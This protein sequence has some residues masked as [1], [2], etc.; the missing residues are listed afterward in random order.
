M[1]KDTARSVWARL[2]GLR[3]SFVTRCERFASLTIPKVLLPEG[4]DKMGNSQTHDYQSMG[5]QCVNHTTNKMMLAMFAP[6]RPFFRMQAGVKTQTKAAEAGVTAE[7]VATIT[8]DAERKAVRKLDE[9]AQ[10][11]KLYALLRHLIV[12]GNALLIRE[13]TSLRVMGLRYFCVK[14]TVTGKVHTLIIKEAV[15]FDELEQAIQ[16]VLPARLKRNP[17]SKIDFFKWIKLEDDGSYTMTQWVDDIDLGT[18]AEKYN[19]VWA[20]EESCPYTVHTWDLADEADYGTGLVEEYEGDFEALS[21]LSEAVVDGAIL[22]TEFRWMCA[23]TGM[24]QVADVQNSKNGDVLAGSIADLAPTQGG[25]PQALQQA[26]AVLTRWEQRIGRG[27][28]MQSAV[29]RDAERVTA[30]EVRMAAFE[31]ETAFGGVYSALAP[32]IQKPLAKWLLALAGVSLD[33]T[34]FTLTIVTGLEAL[35]RNGD[36]DNLRLA[37]QDAAGAA[38]LPPQLLAELSLKR[39]LMFIA[40]GRGIDFRPFFKTDQEKQSDQ[41]A[42]AAQIAQ[43]AAAQS[44]GDNVGAPQPQAQG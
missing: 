41:E 22:G 26:L 29:Q 32:S 18:L 25:N 6:S 15:C 40:D 24:T 38:T 28:L 30:E 2:H 16:D 14:R 17:E 9:V 39:L 33:N 1:R 12:V 35:S 10:R 19:M 5:A 21:A 27:F 37:L 43:Q 23:P 8:A 36:L 34:D 3:S 4:F 42:Q 20:D 44:V 7:D 13:A 31:L 11:P